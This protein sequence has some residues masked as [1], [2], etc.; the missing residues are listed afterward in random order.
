MPGRGMGERLAVDPQ[1][2]KIIYFGARSGNGLW[3]SVDQGVTFTKVTSFTAVGRYHCHV[4]NRPLLM[5]LLGTYFADPTDTNG[6][7]NDIQG[8][9]FI[10][11][12]STSGLTNGA[13]SRIFVGTADKAQSVYVSTNAGSTWTAVAG[14]PTGNLPHKAKL[15][16]AEKALYITYSNTSGPYDGGTGSVHRYDIA[17]STWADI[18]PVTGS[19]AY[20]GY[21]GLGVDLQKP[22]TLVVASLNSW[23]PDAQLFRSNN[24]VSWHIFTL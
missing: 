23:W 14:Q 19:D 17:A 3:K 13:T 2:N 6:Y 8:L 11:F 7:L 12:D 10:T 9:A 1:N 5:S 16:P 22:G 15:Q 4:I 18:S 21:G 20:F 24:S